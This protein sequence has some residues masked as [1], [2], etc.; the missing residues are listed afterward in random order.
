MQ[1]LHT[2]KFSFLFNN[3]K[4]LCDILKQAYVFLIV[5]CKI[6]QLKIPSYETRILFGE[7]EHSTWK[8]IS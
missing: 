4:I 2:F 1:N 8:N 7:H 3:E 6:F 5:N